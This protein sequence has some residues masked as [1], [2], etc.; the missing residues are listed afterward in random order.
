YREGEQKDLLALL[1]WEI[2]RRGYPLLQSFAHEAQ[3]GGQGGKA[4]TAGERGGVE[5]SARKPDRFLYMR[6]DGFGELLEVT[7]LERALGPDGENGLRAIQ[8]E[9]RR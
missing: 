7:F 2:R 9:E 8:S 5:E 1:L 6:V 3:G 4:V